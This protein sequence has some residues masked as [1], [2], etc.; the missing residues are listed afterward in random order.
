[1]KGFTQNLLFSA[2]EHKSINEQHTHISLGGA[3]SDIMDDDMLGVFGFMEDDLAKGAASTQSACFRR[4][5]VISV[6]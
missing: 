6:C 1:V 2:C 5:A 4:G 3:A